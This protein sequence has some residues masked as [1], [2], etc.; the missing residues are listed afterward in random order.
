[1]EFY[2]LFATNPAD[3]DEPDITL[4]SL[5]ADS[6]NDA[7]REHIGTRFRNLSEDDRAFY[8]NDLMKYYNSWSATTSV[9]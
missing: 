6:L 9:C 4:V 3:F 7:F 5:D 1:M 8:E 2:V